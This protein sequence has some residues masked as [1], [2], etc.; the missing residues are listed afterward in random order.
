MTFLQICKFA[1]LQICKTWPPLPRCLLIF[2]D[3]LSIIPRAI[4][5]CSPF[6]DPLSSIPR[7]TLQFS[8]WLEPYNRNH[9]LKWYPDIS[10]MVDLQLKLVSMSMAAMAPKRRPPFIIDGV[11]II[12][13]QLFRLGIGDFLTIPELAQPLQSAA[14]QRPT[15]PQSCIFLYFCEVF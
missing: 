2:T 13:I 10:S 6:T 12:L 9:R 5:Q 8:I 7:A 15:T 11:Q 14:R 4:L 3:P 1:N